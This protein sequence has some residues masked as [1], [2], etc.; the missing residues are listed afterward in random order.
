MPIHPAATVM[1]IR[2]ATAQTGRVGRRGVHAPAPCKAAF[3]AGMLVFPGGRVDDVDGAPDVAA[4]CT[5]LDDAP[6]PSGSG[7][8]RAGSRYWTAVV[9]ESF[10]EAGVL[11]AR[12]TDG[13]RPT[14]DADDRRRVHDG[15]LSMADLCARDD[16]VID[17]SGIHYVDHWVTPL[18]ERR[19][20]DTR[21]FLAEVPPRPGAPA[22][23][24]RDGRQPLGPPRR[25]VGDVRGRPA[26]D[27]AAD[28][29]QSR[30]ARRLR[31]RSPMGSRSPPR[32]IDPPRDPAVPPSR[33]RTGR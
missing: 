14:I 16:L 3:G 27:D 22:R 24:S 12:R 10:E 5:G 20:F 19:R 13:G 6:P 23:R 2:D 26:D 28:D 21:F 32:S 8:H 9:R 1:L 31:D 18:G 29:P 15:E 25:G 7:L 17:L 33:R 4:C 11:L 30:A